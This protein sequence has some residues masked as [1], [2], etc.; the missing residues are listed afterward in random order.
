MTRFLRSTLAGLAAASLVLATPAWAAGDED[1]EEDSSGGEVATGSKLPPLS[2]TPRVAD[3]YVPVD[4]KT[5]AQYDARPLPN[6]AY[7]GAAALKMDPEFVNAIQL[8]LDQL[9]KRDYNAARDTFEAIEGTFPDTAVAE[10]VDMLIWQALMLENFD[11]KYDKQY[12]TSSKAA[13]G[14]LD[15]AMAKPGND[16]WEQLL[17]A[18][19]VGVESIHTMRKSE[20]LSALNLAFQAMDHIEKSKAAA[21]DFIDLTL[22][23]GM[24]NYWRSVV[25]LSSKALPD[26]GDERVKGIEQMQAVAKS[27]IFLKPLANLSL[28]FTWIE[29]GDYKRAA[30]ETAKNRHDYPDSVVNNMVAGTVFIYMK[31][32]PEALKA[33]AEIERV[34]PKNMRVKYWKG[35]A[36]FR[37][38]MPDE[39]LKNFQDYLAYEY[40]EDY[41][42]SWTLYRIGQVYAR[43]KEYAKA[44]ESY[45]AAAK[46]DGH[47]PAKAAADRLKQ[48]KKDGKIDW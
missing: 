13:R 22:A 46:V 47:K 18:T 24:Y 42:K 40:L 8:G 45:E 39:A 41:Q 30:V 29:E 5:I 19:V 9:F 3:G 48:R 6:E 37:S 17:M 25:T 15:K 23:D 11:Y 34:D 4:V 28:A 26:F 10:V 38:K 33:L 27:G 16:A 1:D 21:P 12:W 7:L 44:Y 43:K 14:A 31:D 20:Y 36:Q 2:G 35:V 32:Y